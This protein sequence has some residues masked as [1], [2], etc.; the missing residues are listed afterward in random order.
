[1]I[2]YR[3]L[4]NSMDTAFDE[5]VIEGEVKGKIETAISEF[6]VSS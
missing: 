5:G 4:K 6:L 2:Y 1:M 3:D